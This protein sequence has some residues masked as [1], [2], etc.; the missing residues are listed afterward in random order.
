MLLSEHKI[1][2]CNYLLSSF[3]LKLVMQLGKNNSKV[4]GISLIFITCVITVGCLYLEVAGRITVKPAISLKR[5][6]YLQK[7]NMYS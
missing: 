5:K 2:L 1:T 4:D 7:V 3:E 6:V